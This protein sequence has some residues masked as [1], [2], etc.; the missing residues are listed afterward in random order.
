M[1]DENDIENIVTEILDNIKVHDVRTFK[2]IEEQKEEVLDKI[3]NPF[4]C[5][6]KNARLKEILKD[7]LKGYEFVDDFDNITHYSNIIMIDTTYF[8]DFKYR[9]IG[10]FIKKS[11]DVLLLRNFRNMFLKY[12][13]NENRYYFKKITNKDKVKIMLI[14]TINK[15]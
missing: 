1:Q 15:M 8:F 5:Y 12:K 6:E 2:E 9:H 10:F 7:K 4:L 13:I 11:N 14:E 3:F